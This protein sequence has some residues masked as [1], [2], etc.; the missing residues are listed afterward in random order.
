MTILRTIA[1]LAVLVLPAR[2]LCA[3][4]EYQPTQTEWLEL[5][6]KA[7]YARES[8]AAQLEDM[9]RNLEQ[10]KE[11]GDASTQEV[12]QR[13]GRYKQL[14]K[15]IE[16]YVDALNAVKD[17]ERSREKYLQFRKRLKKLRNTF[18]MIDEAQRDAQ[19]TEREKRFIETAE[20][21]L[22][23]Y[24]H[25]PPER[26]SA[27]PPPKGIRLTWLD[28]PRMDDSTTTQPL[29]ALITS[30]LLGLSMEWYYRPAYVPEVED[31]FQRILVPVSGEL[32]LGLRSPSFRYRRGLGR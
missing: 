8:I 11:R 21:Q 12:E 5:S 27:S 18:N 1:V 3:A 29:A 13:L 10:R 7:Q 24:K 15:K 16:A 2:A 20:Q 28:F 23:N 4:E 32:Q 22:Q 26:I 14:Q 17:E 19:E 30:R 6:T 9:G 25:E 31:S